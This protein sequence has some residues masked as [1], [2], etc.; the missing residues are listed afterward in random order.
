VPSSTDWTFS[1]IQPSFQPNSYV[2]IG[3]YIT[4]KQLALSKY[5]TETYDYPDARSVESMIT[6]SKY[7][8][9]QVGFNYAEAFQLVFSRYRKNR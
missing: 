8:G 1:Q 6:L 2:D 7:R 5:T 9:Y 3:D 4:L